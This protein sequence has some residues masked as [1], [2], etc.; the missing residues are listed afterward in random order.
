MQWGVDR[1]IKSPVN[2]HRATRCVERT[3]GSLKNSIL[4][5]SQEKHPEPLEKMIEWAVGALR[6]S[7]NATLKSSPFEAHHG[8]K[9][10]TVL[11]NLTKKTLSAKSGLVSSTKKIACSDEADPTVGDMPHPTQTNWV[12]VWFGIQ[13]KAPEPC[14]SLNGWAGRKPGWWSIHH[15]SCGTI[16]EAGPFKTLHQQTGIRNLKRYRKIY[17]KINSQSAHTLTLNN[18]VVL[19]KLS[20]AIEK[21]PK[22]SV[23]YQAPPTPKEVKERT[24][25]KTNAGKQQQWRQ[26]RQQFEYS[27]SE[28]GKATTY[29]S[30]Q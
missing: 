3:I 4:T 23:S 11:R 28:S 17:S 19:R 22:T 10:N 18:G 15:L 27:E 21:K 29:Q 8:Q 16:K 1:K 6:F 13:E 7:K 5:F 26:I 9:A 20:V 25:G 24:K 2:D 12:K 14:A 30:Y